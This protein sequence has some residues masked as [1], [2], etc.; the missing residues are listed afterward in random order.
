MKRFLLIVLL[1][2]T[3]LCGCGTPQQDEIKE[4]PSPVQTEERTV[5]ET[6]VPTEKKI[7]GP[8]EEKIT[9][10]IAE[11]ELAEEVVEEN[12][13]SLTVDCTDVLDNM[14]SLKAEKHGIIP[15][16]G[17][18]YAN[19]KVDIKEGDSA[20]DVL[21]RALTS[22]GVHLEFSLT[23]V[24]NSAY[25]EG[26]GNLYEFDCGERSGWKYSVNGEFPRVGC[27]DFKVNP[28]DKIVFIY[29][30]AGY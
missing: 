7:A 18:I 9:E 24:Y 14:D 29:K 20:F 30:V 26:I 27:S 25:I 10:T 6:P 12:M 3:I 19:S 15:Q 4:I 1:S 28:S 8:E 17:I 5:Q 11:P 21:K 16:N 22:S 13:V 23:P 2:A